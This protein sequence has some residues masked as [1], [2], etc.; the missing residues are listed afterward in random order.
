MAAMGASARN[1]IVVG[2]Q[3]QLSQP[4]QGTHPGDSGKSTLEYLLQG[5][6]TIPE[7]QGVLLPITY[8][9]NPLISE[10]I[11]RTVYE[12]R[13]KADKNNSMQRLESPLDERLNIPSEGIGFVEVDHEGCRQQSYEESEV[14]KAHFDQALQRRYTNKEG[15]TKKIEIEDIVVVAP[16]NAQVNYLKAELPIGARVGTIDLFQGQ[17]A[18]IV[19]VSMTSSSRED[20]PRNLD[21]LFSR[22]RMNVAISRAKCLAVIV[23]S[24]RLATA[25]CSNIEQMELVNFFCSIRDYAYSQSKPADKLPRR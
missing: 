21:F 11:S 5:M 10:F 1:I 4:V 6:D 3:M 23:A 9:M 24:R 25:S 18:Q 16:Y 13:L 19:L 8:R 20:I 12:G 7:H 14:I 17:E 15:V 22:N 2:D